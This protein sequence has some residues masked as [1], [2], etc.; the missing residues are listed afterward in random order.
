MLKWSKLLSSALVMSLSLAFAAAADAVAGPVTIISVERTGHATIT[1]AGETNE[2]SFSDPTT[3]DFHGQ[4]TGQRILPV[5]GSGNFSFDAHSDLQSGFDL[6]QFFTD[7]IAA[8][9]GTSID[10]AYDEDSGTGDPSATAAATAFYKLVFRVDEPFDFTIN[11]SGEFGET[12][13]GTGEF[14]FSFTGPDGVIDAA[15][16][17]VLGPG[18]TDWDPQPLAGNLPAGQYELLLSVS[19]SGDDLQ[20]ANA[21]ARFDLQV[22]VPI[23]LPAAVWGGMLALSAGAAALRYCRRIVA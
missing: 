9:V 21:H 2:E 14:E 6:E 16:K 17:S 8:S 15:D 13:A 7:A 12:N 10:L 23:P 4:A 20:R 5:E 22:A 11:R 19:S 1:A 18:E 3:A